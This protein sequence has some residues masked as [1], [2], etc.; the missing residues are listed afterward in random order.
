PH[1]G[2]RPERAHFLPSRAYGKDSDPQ[3]SP[4][5]GQKRRIKAT[6][7]FFQLS[8]LSSTLFRENQLPLVQTSTGDSPPQ[9]GAENEKDIL[10][11]RH[12]ITRSLCPY[13]GVIH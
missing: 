8:S 2:D 3:R 6:G 9:Q 13:Y 12:R 5:S 7:N 4:E 10:P 1:L 11:D